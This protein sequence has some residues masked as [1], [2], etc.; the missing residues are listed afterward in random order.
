V[1]EVCTTA[2]F[3]DS[4]LQ[5]DNFLNFDISRGSV[6]TQLRCGGIINE[7]V[8]N[9]LMNLSVKEF[10]KSVNIWRSYWKYYSGW[11]FFINSQSKAA[12]V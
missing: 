3:I 11:F 5:H 9:L 10:W 8:A 6:V 4:G 1:A 12:D 2:Y 7:S